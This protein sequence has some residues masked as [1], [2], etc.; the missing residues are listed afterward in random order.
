MH[1][2][3]YKI[4]DSMN[5]NVFDYSLEFSQKDVDKLKKNIL[6]WNGVKSC[7]KVV[8]VEDG[9]RVV[10]ASD[11]LSKQDFAIFKK[12]NWTVRRELK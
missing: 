2:L 9:S 4:N 8:V 12:S 10:L 1:T 3:L 11:K 7:A 5:Y 6:L